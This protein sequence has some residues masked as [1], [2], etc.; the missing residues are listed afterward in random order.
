MLSKI[1]KDNH[2]TI[3]I[4]DLAYADDSMWI[5]DCPIRLQTITDIANSFYQINDIQINAEKCNVM[6]YLNKKGRSKNNKQD[7]K[8]NTRFHIGHPHVTLNTTQI[9]IES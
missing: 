3:N 8:L 1:N 4:E 2:H 7:I 9:N 5:S 6:I